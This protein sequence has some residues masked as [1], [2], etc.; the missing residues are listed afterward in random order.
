MTINF[1]GGD[2]GTDANARGIA[3]TYSLGG[4]YSNV[5]NDKKQQKEKKNED[6]KS[7]TSGDR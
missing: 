4:N 7:R 6:S 1:S 5:L 3:D 2:G